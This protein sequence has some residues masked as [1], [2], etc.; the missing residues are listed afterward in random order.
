MK[1]VLCYFS[2]ADNFLEKLLP[3]PYDQVFQLK[4]SPIILLFAKLP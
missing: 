3:S 2:F 4:P 1:D